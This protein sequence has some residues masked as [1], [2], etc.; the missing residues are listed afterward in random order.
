MD[1]SRVEYVQTLCGI[2]VDAGQKRVGTAKTAT[3]L[4]EGSG[5]GGAGVITLDQR[6]AVTGLQEV[7][8]GA[9]EYGGGFLYAVLNHYGWD[10]GEALD[11][12]F[13][14]TLPA[15][16]ATIDRKLSLEEMARQTAELRTGLSRKLDGNLSV[17]NE[18]MRGTGEFLW[19]CEGL[20]NGGG[21][22][23]S[24]N[25]SRGDVLPGM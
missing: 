7:L 18:V 11:G 8:G 6:R 15:V 25:G 13:G 2:N 12:I 4:F 20:G 1:R 21:V 19:C 14:G 3:D 17:S 22:R 24:G 5:G 10:Q 9:E 23:V 16:V